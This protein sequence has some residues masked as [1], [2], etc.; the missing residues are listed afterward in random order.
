M[1]TSAVGSGSTT[2]FDLPGEN[3]KGLAEQHTTL[4]TRPQ[5][6][7][8]ATIRLVSATSDGFHSKPPRAVS[9]GS[10][11]ATLLSTALPL[12]P[13]RNP[14]PSN[15]VVTTSTTSKSHHT[16]NIA[17]SVQHQNRDAS[18][19]SQSPPKAPPSQYG[20][21]STNTTSGFVH[22]ANV[23]RSVQHRN[24]VSPEMSKRPIEAPCSQFQPPTG[25]SNS[26]TADER[27]WT[28]R[29]ISSKTF[30][31]GK[32]RPSGTAVESSSQVPCSLARKDNED[33]QLSQIHSRPQRTVP[34]SIVNTSRR[35]GA[36]VTRAT[37]PRLTSNHALTPGSDALRPV[38]NPVPVV[39]PSRDGFESAKFVD[40]SNDI[41]APATS[42]PEPRWGNT[43]TIGVYPP[44]WKQ[45][46]PVENSSKHPAHSFCA[47]SGSSIF[48]SQQNQDTNFFHSQGRCNNS[49]YSGVRNNRIVTG[50]HETCPVNV[51]EL[52]GEQSET[53]LSMVQVGPREF[54]GCVA[55]EPE[56]QPLPLEAVSTHGHIHASGQSRSFRR[57]SPV[58]P[59]TPQDFSYWNAAMVETRARAIRR[60]STAGQWS[61][62]SYR[63][64]KKS[65]KSTYQDHKML[66]GA[67]QYH[68]SYSTRR[69]S[70]DGIA[71]GTPPSVNEFPLDLLVS[72]P[73]A[74]AVQVRPSRSVGFRGLLYRSS[75]V[76]SWNRSPVPKRRDE[77]ASRRQFTSMVQ[78]GERVSRSS[79]CLQ[80]CGMG[81]ESFMA[82][83][84]KAETCRATNG[85]HEVPCF[86]TSYRPAAKPLAQEFISQRKPSN[87]RTERVPRKL[88]KA[89][90][91]IISVRQ[92]YESEARAHDEKQSLPPHCKPA[93]RAPVFKDKRV[94]AIAASR[95]CDKGG[96]RSTVNFSRKPG[97]DAYNS[98]LT[99]RSD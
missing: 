76:L 91:R 85:E 72:T 49:V 9:P 35:R 53:G 60:S 47:E 13:Y 90:R 50:E 41:D 34:C 18:E 8:R 5:P 61:T 56:L 73:C 88:G 75:R 16:A 24:H 14:T 7:Q 44:S 6:R 63:Q 1:P 4:A 87:V 28:T 78:D 38:W 21:R 54:V 40:P 59:L 25:P 57:S 67:Q 19:I 79:R 65:S 95:R 22:K 45:A 66:N 17:R 30:E 39:A 99:F 98:S 68:P 48:D 36:G 23:P 43:A 82:A 77:S 93:R 92:A 62:P 80:L 86:S 15:G 10:R 81:K 2:Q 97:K 11:N 27:V 46:P 33:D 58:S 37:T 26:P 55:L 89:Q 12:P 51:R 31:P 32:R 74:T 64:S 3:A 70:W 83:S 71:S 94:H 42:V 69:E 96:G 52:D 84:E 29:S 20:R